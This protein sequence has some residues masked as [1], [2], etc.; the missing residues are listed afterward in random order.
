MNGLEVL[1]VDEAPVGLGVELACVQMVWAEFKRLE[2]R[3]RRPYLGV[4]YKF[5]YGLV[6]AG[7]EGALVSLEQGDFARA[8]EHLREV[9]ECIR[10]VYVYGNFPKML[11]ECVRVFGVEDV[12]ERAEKVRGLWFELSWAWADNSCKGPTLTPEFARFM[13][14]EWIVS[15]ALFFG[16]VVY[17]MFYA[18]GWLKLITPVV[19]VLFLVPVALTGFI[20]RSLIAAIIYIPITALGFYVCYGYLEKMT[21]L[22]WVGILSPGSGLFTGFLISMHLRYLA[23]SSRVGKYGPFSCVWMRKLGKRLFEVVLVDSDRQIVWRR[24]ISNVHVSLEPVLAYNITNTFNAEIGN[25]FYGGSGAEGAEWFQCYAPLVV[26]RMCGL[27]FRRPRHWVDACRLTEG[28]T[29]EGLDRF[30]AS[31]PSALV[32]PHYEELETRPELTVP[33]DAPW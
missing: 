12:L 16:P 17:P 1:R 18:Q 13:I 15:L 2:H 9:N 6:G 24:F 31:M 28:V 22:P 3:G 7:L 11:S 33:I 14:I 10:G 30:F 19:Y 25:S 23:S 26:P 5:D 27:R 8:L 20:K 29:K 21:G 4:T 32:P